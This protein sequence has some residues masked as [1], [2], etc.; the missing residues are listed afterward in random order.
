MSKQNSI[1]TNNIYQSLNK[2]IKNYIYIIFGIY[3]TIP[4]DMQ[5]LVSY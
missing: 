1:I 2:H 5:S 4:V 3:I